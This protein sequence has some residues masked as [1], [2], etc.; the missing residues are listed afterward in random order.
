MPHPRDGVDDTLDLLVTPFRAEVYRSLVTDRGWPPERFEHWLG[1]T[2]MR[3]PLAW[4]PPPGSST[5]SSP[6]T[7]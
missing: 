1:D 5:P 7:A 4:C 6:G 2:L 3:D